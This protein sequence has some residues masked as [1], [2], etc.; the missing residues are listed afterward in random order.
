M[1]NRR[2]RLSD[3]KYEDVGKVDD[4]MIVSKRSDR[5]NQEMHISIFH[6]FEPISKSKNTETLKITCFQYTSIF[7][8]IKNV[9]PHL[10]GQ[11]RALLDKRREFSEYGEQ[12]IHSV[13]IA[14]AI[15]T[16]CGG[17]LL[18]QVNGCANLLLHCYHLAHQL[19]ETRFRC[20]LITISF[21]VIVS[22]MANILIQVNNIIAGVDHS[23][24]L[25]KYGV[26]VLKSSA[27]AILKGINE[28]NASR[29][30]AYH[31]LDGAVNTL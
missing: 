20:L 17:Q 8:E 19:A 14:S 26:Q 24:Y 9:T 29:A 28:I 1:T 2:L 22:V 25:I 4:Y 15:N 7:R 13:D 11:F 16:R 31:P 5:L 23:L 21:S 18:R 30:N 10:M 3:L 6:G 27:I 12:I